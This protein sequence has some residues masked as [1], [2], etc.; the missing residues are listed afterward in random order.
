MY[1]PNTHLAI[2]RERHADLLREARKHELASHAHLAGGRTSLSRRVFAL[3][4][5]RRIGTAKPVLHGAK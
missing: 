1:D 2:A 4:R 5:L 3:L